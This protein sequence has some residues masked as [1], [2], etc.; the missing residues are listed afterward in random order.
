MLMSSHEETTRANC[1]STNR[2]TNFRVFE[3]RIPNHIGG[4]SKLWPS[5]CKVISQRQDIAETS[6]SQ[7]FFAC[8]DDPDGGG[9]SCRVGYTGVSPMRI[10]TKLYQIGSILLGLVEKRLGISPATCFVGGQLTGLSKKNYEKV[11]KSRAARRPD[12]CWLV[13]NYD[14]LW[15]IGNLHPAWESI[16]TKTALPNAGF[17]RGSIKITLGR[18][19]GLYESPFGCIW[20]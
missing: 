20:K 15:Y 12:S 8:E 14:Y 3:R 11:F 18:S 10:R 5:F 6:A 16:R 7:P 4:V 17:C 1:R 13:M 2:L 9:L 19:R